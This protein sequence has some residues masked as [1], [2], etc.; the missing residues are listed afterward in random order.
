[1]KPR[2]RLRFCPQSELSELLCNAG[3]HREDQRLLVLYWYQGRGRIKSNE[4]LVKWDLLRDSALR[5][6]SDE[7]LVRIVVPV[8]KSEEEAFQTAAR[9][10][11]A[12]AT[13]LAE[14]LP[15]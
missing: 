6:R 14:A 15:I 9:V 2:S 8:T 13:N 10:A 5:Q 11:D 12:V 3:V 7:A 4:Y 1:M